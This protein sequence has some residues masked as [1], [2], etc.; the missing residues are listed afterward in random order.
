MTPPQPPHS[1]PLPT[2]E[3]YLARMPEDLRQQLE[4]TGPTGVLALS[5]A[6][7]YPPPFSSPPTELHFR[8]PERPPT[9]DKK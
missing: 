2:W 6:M 1:K 7:G 9:A 8:S 5:Q 4:E 3:E